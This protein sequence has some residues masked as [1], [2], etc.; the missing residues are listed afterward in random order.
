LAAIEITRRKLPHPVRDGARSYKAVLD[1]RIVGKLRMGDV[2]K[3][4]VQ[5]G[6]HR[7]CIKID[8]KKSNSIAFDLGPD[9]V[10]RFA[11]EPGGPYMAA[12]FDLFKAE[13]YVTLTGA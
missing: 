4:D 11:C 10:E 12:F 3:L 9:T 5:P 6:P 2:L 8:F 1:G 13:G 7:L